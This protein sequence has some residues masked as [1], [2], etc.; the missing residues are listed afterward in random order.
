MRPP[1]D[2]AESVRIAFGALRA[3]KSRGALTALGIIVGLVAVVTTMTAANGLQNRFRES[4]SAVGADV[5]YVS[6]MPWVVMN[7]FFQ[8]RNRPPIDLREARALEDKLRGKA[9]V[10]PTMD[11]REDAKYRD[12]TMEGVNVI[13]T[14]DKQTALSSAQ[15][16]FGRFL[17]SFDVYYK[18]NV[19]VIGS[20]I[21]E[22]LFGVA[23]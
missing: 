8:F 21:R 18:R 14:T 3:N 6:R 19:C 12:E 20:A 9:V 2:I 1:L 11:S 15:P 10:N 4:F 13:G 22:G 5:V 23:D 7:D 16:Q 17:L